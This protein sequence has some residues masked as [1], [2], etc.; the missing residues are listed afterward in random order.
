MIFPGLRQLFTRWTSRAK[1]TPTM[2][3]GVVQRQ[4]RFLELV[5]EAAKE[6]ASDVHIS[7]HALGW[8]RGA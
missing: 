3:K 4:R 6:P 7:L 2:R 5:S 1:G 8:K